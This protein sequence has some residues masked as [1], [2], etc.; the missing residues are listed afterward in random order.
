MASAASGISTARQL[1]AR[2]KQLVPVLNVAG[3]VPVSQVEL[4]DRLPDTDGDRMATIRLFMPGNTDQELVMQFDQ[5]MVKW[6]FKM[7]KFG[8]VRGVLNLKDAEATELRALHDH[9]TAHA[10]KNWGDNVVVRPCVEDENQVRFGWPTDKN[11]E[12]KQLSVIDNKG[13]KFYTFDRA[14]SRM[15]TDELRSVTATIR[16]WKRTEDGGRQVLG[17][18]LTLERLEF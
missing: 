14:I 17:Y 11:R 2:Q 13:E 15:T 4:T 1:F 16:L 6:A 3:G 18:Y 9:V 10:L 5:P 8:K 7:D 12:P